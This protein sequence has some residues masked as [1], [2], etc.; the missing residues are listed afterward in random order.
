VIDQDDFG[1]TG[2]RSTRVIFGA[3]A[4]GS[5]RQERADQVLETL[6][7]YGVNHLDTARSYGD[8]EL[9]LAPRLAAHPGRFFLATKTGERRA[10]RARAELEESL[11]RLG[12]C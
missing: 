11:E 2:H 4:L 1:R 10:S 3:A 5:M 12:L 7:A 6:L 9:R 8:A